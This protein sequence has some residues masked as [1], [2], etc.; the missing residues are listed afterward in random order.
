MSENR[1]ELMMY[2]TEDGQTK[3]DVRMENETVWLSLDQMAELF[4]RDKSTISRH[5]RN[6]F[7]EGELDR[8]AVVAKFATTASDGKTYQ[9]DFYNLDVI[10][11]VGYRVRSLRGTQFR[12]WANSVLKEYLIKGFAMNDDRLK[13]TGGKD[14]FDEL[15][16]RVRD[17]R[18]SEKVFWRKVLDIYAT[19]ATILPTHG[20]ARFSFRQYRTRCSMLHRHDCSGADRQPCRCAQTPDGNDRSKREPSH[21]GGGQNRKELSVRG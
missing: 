7:A 17:I 1:T 15:L 10:I 6:I 18:S 12:I 16:E 20:K 11:S 14:Y 8:E 3:I 21:P 9:V 19:S 13:D 2:Q 5:I 4:Q